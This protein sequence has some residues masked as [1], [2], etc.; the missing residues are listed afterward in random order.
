MKIALILAHKEQRKAFKNIHECL[1]KVYVV[2]YALASSNLTICFQT[3]SHTHA[4][5]LYTDI[6]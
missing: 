3:S 1:K 4:L 5:V 6:Y 2:G